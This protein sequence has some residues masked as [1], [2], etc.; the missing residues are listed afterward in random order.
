[1]EY[2]AVYLNYIG[3]YK[4]K[5]DKSEKIPEN[6]FAK[7]IL[8]S[9]ILEKTEMNK[10]SNKTKFDFNIEKYITE[11]LKKSFIVA[12]Y[13]IGEEDINKKMQIL[14]CDNINREEIKQKC[15]IYLNNNKIDFT[16]EYTFNN[17]GKYTFKF[18][19]S[20]LLTNA[21]KLFYE[22]KSLISLNVEKFKSNYIKD[23]SDMF[24]GCSKLES[25][26]LSN[27]KTRE[28]LSMKS[29]IKKCNSLKNVDLS[30]FD[31]KNVTDM[32]EMFCDC[33]SLSFL[34]LSNFN[35]EKVTTMYRMF[36]NCKS[37]YFVNLSSFQSNNIITISEMF[38]DCSSMNSLDLSNFEI[39]NNIN[40]DKLFYNCSYFKS[41]KNEFLSEIENDNMERSIEVICKEFL[42][43]EQKIHSHYIQSFFKKNKI[44]DIQ[45]LNQAIKD[46]LSQINHINILL[47]GEEKVGKTT[48]INSLI[49]ENKELFSILEI[50]GIN[51]TNMDLIYE[52][53]LNEIKESKPD[54]KIHFIWFCFNGIKLSVGSQYILSKLINKFLKDIPIFIIYLKNK[55]KDEYNK[56]IENFNNMYSNISLDIIP[57][58][59]KNNNIE[60]KIEFDVK[61]IITKIKN[62]FIELLY[63][64]IHVNTDNVMD[65]VKMKIEEIK[66]DNNLD[67]PDS[68]AN[69]FEKLLG[70]RDDII[71]YLR[72]ISKS[73]SQYSKRVTDIDTI[74]SLIDKFKAEKLKLKVVKTKNLDIESI[75]EE[76]NKE[77]ISFYSKISQAFYEQK[78]GEIISKF[79]KDFIKRE[80]EKIILQT[81]KDLTIENLKPSIE[82]ILNLKI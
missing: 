75:D 58:L 30:S 20:D 44:N 2:F 11:D 23:M 13:D 45:I 7:D 32:S 62:S 21:N 25:L 1:M 29:M 27:F 39:N 59:P 80:A 71:K 42:S 38:Y 37:L 17:P 22:C 34:N 78:Y 24:N 81:L 6:D 79:F 43:N 14:N 55:E 5:I 3:E 64:E 40:T 33:I 10:E 60:E 31:T 50:E 18:E 72:G 4:T 49:S 69:H 73:S 68:V 56:F 63:K 28:V 51:N 35:T 61:D 8:Q 66:P 19:F 48:L 77:L 82:N 74:S 76:L 41:L 57:V 70:K 46:Y 65:I 26:D 47:L 36:Y 54:K 12:I 67:L 16:F 9:Q 52:N 15:N 53:I